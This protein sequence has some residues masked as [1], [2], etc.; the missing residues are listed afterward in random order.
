MADMTRSVMRP[1]LAL[2]LMLGLFGA[3]AADA[4]P[5]DVTVV[6]SAE[7]GKRADARAAVERAGGTVGGRLDVVH[8]F[9]ARVPRSAI[10]RLRRADAIRSV[11]RDV[12]LHLSDTAVADRT[13][14]PR[15]SNRRRP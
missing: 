15:R 4:R 10:A 2:V 9:T 6:V 11:V 1:L 3:E 12:P 8:G 7:P 14:P 13:R 5:A